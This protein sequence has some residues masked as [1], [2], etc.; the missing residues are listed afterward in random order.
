MMQKISKKEAKAAGLKRFFTGD[1]CKHG[2]VA[3]RHVSSSQCFECSR[4]KQKRPSVKEF[5]AAHYVANKEKYKSAAKQRYCDNREEKLA[6]A[7]QYQRQ[8]LKRLVA[9][10]EANK[11]KKIAEQPWLA[12]K[13]RAKASA[14]AALKRIGAKKNQRTMHLLGCTS[15]E[16]KVHIERQFTKGMAWGNRNLWHLDHIVPLASAKTETEV[17][18]LC[19]FTNLRPCWAVDNIKKSDKREFLL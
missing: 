19:H 11:R 10:R 7:T 9:Q 13:Y 3:E 6:Y 15:D 18:A 16:L 17:L 1:L 2:H 4:E 8:N 12:L 14:S 5:K